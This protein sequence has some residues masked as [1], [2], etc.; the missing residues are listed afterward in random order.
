MARVKKLHLQDHQS[1]RCPKRFKQIVGNA[2]PPKPPKPPKPE[3]TSS[4]PM[5]QILEMKGVK[6]K[7]HYSHYHDE[8][9]FDRLREQ[10]AQRDAMSD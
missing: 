9:Q 10:K 1:K 8:D 6:R 5:R 3:I 7:P 4:P 2:P